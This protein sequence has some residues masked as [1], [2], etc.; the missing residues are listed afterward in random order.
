MELQI[1][2]ISLEFL[3]F[4]VPQ[5]II[6]DIIIIIDHWLSLATFLASLDVNCY[7]QLKLHGMWVA[8]KSKIL[9]TTNN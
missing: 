5:I 2:C 3:L 7:N 8:A 4:N 9:V 1:F 6:S